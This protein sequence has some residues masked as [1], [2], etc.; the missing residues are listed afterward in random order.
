MEK[1]STGTPETS[2]FDGTAWFDLIEAGVR[3]RIRGFIET[4]LE[5]ELTTALGRERYYR[6]GE[7]AG[8]D[9]AAR[10]SANVQ[11]LLL[12]SEA[13]DGGEFLAVLPPRSQRCVL[14]SLDAAGKHDHGDVQ[15]ISVIFRQGA[16]L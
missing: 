3:E 8:G 14:V 10:R 15:E 7:A 12:G 13:G 16:W 5:E 9:R 4:M 6:D 2:L 11:I 1:N